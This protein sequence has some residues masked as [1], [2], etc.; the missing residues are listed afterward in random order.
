M[1]RAHM[2]RASH[3]K[4]THNF[5]FVFFDRHVIYGKAQIS[6]EEWTVDYTDPNIQNIVLSIRQFKEIYRTL[7][8]LKKSPCSLP[9]IEIFI[10]FFIFFV[11]KGKVHNIVQF[12]ISKISNFKFLLLFT[13]LTLSNSL[14]SS[15]LILCSLAFSGV[16]SSSLFSTFLPTF[17]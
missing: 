16:S 10:L 2:F 12:R 5:L 4:K 8:D 15:S 7:I 17:L 9:I 13:Y 1:I 3:N 11:C 14:R 6:R